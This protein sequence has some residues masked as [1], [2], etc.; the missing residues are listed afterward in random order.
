MYECKC[1]RVLSPAAPAFPASGVARVKKDVIDVCAS[2]LRAS[3]RDDQEL[4][5]FE[6]IFISGGVSFP[7]CFISGGVSFPGVFHFRA[8]KVSS[9]GKS[10]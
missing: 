3:W 2:I 10:V 8:A 6:G 4:S 7:G 5:I 1:V 9:A